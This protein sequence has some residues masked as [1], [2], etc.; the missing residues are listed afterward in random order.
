[1][2]R[3]RTSESGRQLAARLRRQLIGTM[4]VANLSGAA[5]VF[6]FLVALLPE[7]G[8][9]IHLDALTAVLGVYIVVALPVAVA[10]SARRSEVYWRW[11]REERQPDPHERELALREPQRGLIVAATGW[12]IAAVLF[13]AIEAA[14][15]GSSH[16]ASDVGLTILL[17]GVTTCTVTYVLAEWVLRPVFTRVLAAG[18]PAEPVGPS[19][20]LRLVIGWALATGVPVLGIAAVAISALS[21]EHR[22]ID[23]LAVSALILAVAALLA[24]LVATL[25]IA[26][27]LARSIH[28]VREAFARIRGGDYDARVEVDDGGEIGL[29]QV[30]FNEMAD[31]VRERERIREA[32]GT[33]LDRDVAEHILREGTSL[34]GEEVEVT[35]LFMDV[36]DFTAFAEHSSAPEVV[37]TLNR[38]W[39]CVVPIIHAHGGH[40]DKFVG[41]GLL[42]VFGA[43]RRQEN[44][45]DQGLAAATEIERAVHEWFPEGLEIGIGLNSGMVVAGN[46][47]G[48][49]RLE[50]SVIG[51]PVNVAARVETATRQTG[52]A[53]L[54]AEQ[55]RRLLRDASVRLEDRPGVPLKGRQEAVALY[56]PVTEVAARAGTD[57][58]SA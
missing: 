54:V 17:G 25:A 32:F 10:W 48:A 26:K 38:L 40:V 20:G 30:G 6:A 53:I 28:S 23:T 7:P 50:F 16:E 29:L 19:V 34:S 56:A 27:T 2:A 41:D 3:K 36:R 39:E 1:M 21:G 57:R 12:A 24:G 46:V 49:G 33:Y 42:A 47:G 43:P 52:D 18:P 22:D 5:V 4:L 31:S 35:L 45:A 14:D 44:H 8:G 9:I 51:D 58:A 15:S 13:A 55:T 11:L 37:A